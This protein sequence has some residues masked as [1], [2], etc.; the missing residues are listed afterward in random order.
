MGKVRLVPC[1]LLGLL[2]LPG[3]ARADDDAGSE[4]GDIAP[5]ITATTWINTEEDESPFE[6]D[7]DPQLVML[8]FWG[9]W[10]GPC[11]RSMPKVQQLWDRYRG[12][13]LLVVAITREAAGEVRG[14]LKENGYTMPVACDPSQACISEFTLSG[15]PSTYLIDRDG[16][17]LWRGA[18]YGVEPEIEKALGLESSPRTLLTQCLDAEAAKDKDTLR[19]AL[20]RLVAKAPP[21]FDLVDWAGAALGE[22]PPAAETPKTF[23]GKAALKHL[24][25]LRKAWKDE[26]KRKLL[27]TELGS[28]EAEPVDLQ[29]WARIWY[30]K[31]FPFKS[32]ELKELLAAKRYDEILDMFFLRSPSGSLYKLAAKD[33]A[34]VRWCNKKQKD[35]FVFARKGI[36]G[37]TYW[38][39]DEPPPEDFDSEAFSR[40]ISVSGLVTSESRTKVVGIM[41]GGETVMKGVMPG[42]IDRQLG[43]GFLMDAIAAG[44]PL[45]VQKLQKKIEGEKERILKALRR[46]YG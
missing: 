22:L 6:G 43:R 28:G 9:T 33:D 24:D 35:A 12:H 42:W 40:D 30:V 23:K 25:K 15:W 41:I 45:K 11:V 39:S 26:E 46:K 27:L 31:A 21:K 4:P 16:K 37:L 34:L 20:E 36:M 38:M 14:F 8:E 10:C 3:V 2:W 17:I 18:P 1:I 5:E 44:K 13:G 19:G 32:D 29:D 7:T